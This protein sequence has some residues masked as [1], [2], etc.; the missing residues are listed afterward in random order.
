MIIS[1]L[2]GGGKDYSNTLLNGFS[3]ARNIELIDFF[4][5]GWS[6]GMLPQENFNL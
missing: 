1:E 6:G 2:R 3:L 5:L 4:K